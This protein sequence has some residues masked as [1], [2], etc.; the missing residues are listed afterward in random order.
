VRSRSR[1][2]ANNLLAKVRQIA[3]RPRSGFDP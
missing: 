3:G 2:I 1:R